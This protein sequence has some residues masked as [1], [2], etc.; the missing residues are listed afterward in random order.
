MPL[1]EPKTKE[2]NADFLGRCMGD[3]VMVEEYPDQKQ[4]AAVCRSQYAKDDDPEPLEKFTAFTLSESTGSV[5]YQAGTIKDI[6]IL[7][8]GEAKG[9]RMMISQKTLESS[10]TLLLGK[11]LPAYLS[12]D[13]ATGD[14]LLTEAGYF[15][16]FYRDK[17][18][19]RATRFV[20]LESFKK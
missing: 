6:S 7:T 9:H 20:A 8:V 4:R 13:G 18:K 11:T 19:I 3:D 1:P 17:D 14:R 16:G 5:D 15:S 10:I 12:H 2:S